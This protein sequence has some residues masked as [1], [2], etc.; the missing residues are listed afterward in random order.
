[1]KLSVILSFSAATADPIRRR[2][3]LSLFGPALLEQQVISLDDDS[4]SRIQT[5]D[6]FH[7]IA[8]LNAYVHLFLFVSLV[9]GNEHDRLSLIRQDRRLRNRDRSA[10]QVGHDFYVREH[11]R[12]QS[13]VRVWNFGAH[14]YRPGIR[15]DNWIDQN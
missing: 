14:L 8:V 6:D 9:V 11:I 7:S 10:I 15:V 1:M 13:T 3:P 4:V 5:F 2:L 12:L